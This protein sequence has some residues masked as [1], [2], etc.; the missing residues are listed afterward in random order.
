MAN[1]AK[2]KLIQQHNIAIEAEKQKD[3]LKDLYEKKIFDME[4]NF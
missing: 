1:E 3:S 2:Y 4:M